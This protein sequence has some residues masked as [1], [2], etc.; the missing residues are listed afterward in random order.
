MIKEYGNVRKRT[1]K[2]TD[3]LSHIKVYR[4]EAKLLS[5][6]PFLMSNF[7]CFQ[8]FLRFLP[9]RFAKKNRLM[10]CCSDRVFRFTLLLHVRLF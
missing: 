5:D 10:Q 2:N 7:D 9:R 4:D 8:I 6:T 1:K 3:R